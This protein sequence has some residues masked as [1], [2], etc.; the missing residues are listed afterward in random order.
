MAQPFDARSLRTTGDAVPVGERITLG[1]VS[2]H[3]S[4]SAEGV[5]AY[6][7]EQASASS[8]L[9]WV[10]R[11]GR[12]LSEAAPGGQYRDFALSPD[13][14]R[15]AFGLVVSGGTSE[16]IW[17]RDLARGTSSRLTFGQGQNI[18]PI[19][20]PDGSRVVWCSNR[21]G[22]FKIY[23]RLA[24]G[25]G[26]EDS[27]AH[28]PSGQDGPSDW[29]RDGRF[30]VVTRYGATSWDVSVLPKD[31]DRKPLDLIHSPYHERNGMLSPDGRWL[32]YSSTESGRAEIYVTSFPGVEG[33]WQISTAGGVEP[34]WRA[35]GREI[36]YRAPDGSIMAVPVQTDREVQAGQPVALFRT[37]LVADGF[38]RNRWAPAA[39]GQRF[40][41]NVPLGNAT[42][43]RFAVVVN[44]ARELRR[45]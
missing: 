6:R 17:V 2:G 16:D 44:W 10:D 31:G 30:V 32:V 28:V 24:S 45:K 36:F 8:H 1:S 37:V 39:D 15:V 12:E 19:W 29:S 13:G 18:W 35:D 11:A 5:L 21:T 3:F 23:T 26:G 40:L 42:G 25:A 22:D 43:A 27:L 9:V 20:T 14:R 34:F 7:V 33:R 4:S 41:L 38:V